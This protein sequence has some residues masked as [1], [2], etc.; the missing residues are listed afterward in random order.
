MSNG[1]S[2]I[3]NFTCGDRDLL[4]KLDTKLDAY[5]EEVKEI[6][7]KQTWF[8]RTA[9]GSLLTALSAAIIALVR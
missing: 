4:V 5:H 8:S 6:K 1:E 9:I 3:I 2:Q 7:R